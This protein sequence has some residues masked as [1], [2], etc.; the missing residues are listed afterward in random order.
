VAIRQSTDANAAP[1]K[2]LFISLLTRDISLI[3]AL[4]DVVDNSI[5]S[6]IKKHRLA[7]KNADDYLKLLKLANGHV[8][9]I[10]IFVSE[11][12][13]EIS[14]DT[15]GISFADAK[16]D[17]FR[18]G[19][20]DGNSSEDRLSVYGIGLKRAI[21][22]MGNRIEIVSQHPDTG[23]ELAIDVAKWSADRTQPWKF[24]NL[25]PRKAEKPYGTSIK[26]SDLT[27]D[28][29]TRIKDP[30]FLTE[31]MT[32]LGETY[33]YYLEHLISITINSLPV[34]A[35]PLRIGTNFSSAIFSEYNV[36]CSVTAGIVIPPVDK[37]LADIS[38]LFVFCNGRAVAFADKS[39]ITGWGVKGLLPTFQPKHRPFIGIVFFAATRP[40]ALPWSTTKSSIN[41]ESLLWQLAKRK[42]AAASREIINFL[43]RRYSEA[44]TL[45][46]PE[47]LRASAG[48]SSISLF[49]AI[50][51]NEAVFK[52]P[53]HPQKPIREYKSISYKALAS[54]VEAVKKY[55]GDQ[56]MTN[57][58][59]GKYTF[60]Y[61][62]RNEVRGR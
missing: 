6:A 8:S 60:D 3:D 51:A 33:V 41:Q 27:D 39:E 35:T 53:S 15:G 26:I 2:R 25:T 59:V 7:L 20:E 32:R 56:T 23:F 10:S 4:L 12:T 36:H 28:V 58:D 21:F 17:V 43:D 55:V 42:I 49:Q 5:N 37:F 9:R 62:V 54:H 11:A 48:K 14:D 38:G 34:R 24:K 31:L 61:F 13:I 45:V 46:S 1:E 47:Q 22:K 50:G 52:A 44:G 18:F 19:R 16:D 57:G 30:T 29:R 40:E